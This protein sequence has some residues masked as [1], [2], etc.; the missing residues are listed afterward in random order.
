MKMQFAFVAALV[1]VVAAA[2]ATTHTS[3]LA[4]N[5]LAVEARQCVPEGAAAAP[6]ANAAH[7]TAAS[8]ACPTS[9]LA[10]PLWE[11]PTTRSRGLT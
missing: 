6:T 4:A 11:A 3:L 1:A 5:P 8:A 9:P 10:G 7:G 2:P